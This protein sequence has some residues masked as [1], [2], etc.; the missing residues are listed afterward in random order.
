MPVKISAPCAC[1][2]CAYLI[3]KVWGAEGKT[4][5]VQCFNNDRTCIE[6]RKFAPHDKNW[7]PRWKQLGEE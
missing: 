3:R 7:C 5:E 2:N 1:Y 6:K 4:N